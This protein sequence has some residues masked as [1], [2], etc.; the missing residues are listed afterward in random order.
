M[1]EVFRLLDLVIS[2]ELASYVNRH[3]DLVA[4][5]D[6]IDLDATVRARRLWKAVACFGWAHLCVFA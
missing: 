6:A 3:R 2:L 4:I 1:A 5:G